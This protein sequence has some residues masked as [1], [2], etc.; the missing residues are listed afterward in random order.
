[1]TYSGR[2]TVEHL[3][4]TT[5]LTVEGT[6]PSHAI[7][8]T[9]TLR[10][11]LTWSPTLPINTDFQ[12]QLTVSG[13][14][15]RFIAYACDTLQSEART[16]D[17]CRSS[18]KKSHKINGRDVH[19]KNNYNDS[20]WQEAK[21]SAMLQHSPCVQCCTWSVV[22]STRKQHTEQTCFNW[23]QYSVHFHK[24]RTSLRGWKHLPLGREIITTNKDTPNSIVWRFTS[25][26]HLSTD[27]AK[28]W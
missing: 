14:A 4:L 9:F 20:Y 26:T 12:S 3:Q 8:I 21:G 17:I 7:L 25:S 18:K 15:A 6:H 23:Q 24:H 27:T 16:M 5:Y 22:E 11:C 10:I 19:S 13:Y 1:M 2:H 28:H